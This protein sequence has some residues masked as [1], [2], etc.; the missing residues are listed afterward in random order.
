MNPTYSILFIYLFKVIRSHR[1]WHQSKAH[2][3]SINQA[4]FIY[5]RQP[6]PIE[7]WII[8]LTISD[9]NL[10]PIFTVSEI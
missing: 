2:I 1:F 7:A 4:I 10:P 8:Q 6:E 3:Q 9:Y 5:I